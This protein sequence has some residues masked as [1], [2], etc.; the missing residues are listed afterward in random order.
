VRLFQ[1]GSILRIDAVSPFGYPYPLL[2]VLW[3]SSGRI[4]AGRHLE[5]ARLQSLTIPDGQSGYVAILADAGG[6]GH[7][8]V[9]T[10]CRLE[11]APAP[12]VFE[13][14]GSVDGIVVTILFQESLVKIRHNSRWRPLVSVKKRIDK[15]PLDGCAIKAVAGGLSLRSTRLRLMCQ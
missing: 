2:Q 15:Q 10:S 13:R 7:E 3:I 9:V 11:F 14:A 4:A 12:D 1:R 5:C 6:N 8:G